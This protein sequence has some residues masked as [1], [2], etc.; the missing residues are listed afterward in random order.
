MQLGST[1]GERSESGDGEVK[2]REGYHVDSQSPEINVELTGES[3]AGG[4]SGHGGRDEMVE[5]SIGGCSVYSSVLVA[6]TPSLR[7]QPSAVF[8][9]MIVHLAI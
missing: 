1:A 7:L 3:E 8:Y 6:V 2:L 5:I 9:N 4:Y